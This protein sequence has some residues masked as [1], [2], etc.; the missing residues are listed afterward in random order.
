MKKAELELELQRTQR[1]LG[2]YQAALHAALNHGIEYQKVVQDEEH[3]YHRITARRLMAAHG[4]L[5]VVHFQPDASALPSTRAW[6]LDDFAKCYRGEAT[7]LG[8][9]LVHKFRDVADEICALRASMYE[10]NRRRDRCPQCAG[11]GLVG[12]CHRCNGKGFL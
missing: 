5:V 4:G 1:E 3:G 2:M 7:H 10:S 6:Y 9:G 8:Y 11:G 12:K